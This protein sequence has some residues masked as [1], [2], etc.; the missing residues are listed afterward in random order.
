[1]ATAKKKSPA[2]KSTTKSTAART[3]STSTTRTVAA[4]RSD[5]HKFSEVR[6]SDQTV[7]WLIIGAAVVALAAWT[8]SLQLKLNDVYNNI[9]VTSDST[10]VR[11]HDR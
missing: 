10:V 6:V 2:R 11:D 8:L 3:R 4:K 5:D 7:Y 1:M 9:E